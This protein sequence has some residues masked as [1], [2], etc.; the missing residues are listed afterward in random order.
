MGA[1]LLFAVLVLLAV[2]VGCHHRPGLPAIKDAGALRID[3]LDLYYMDGS[4]N[5]PAN[6]WPRAID[7]LYPISV[8]RQPD[9]IEILIKRKLGVE[10]RGYWICRD[11]DAKP[12][13]SVYKLSKTRDSGVYQFDLF[14]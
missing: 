5:I 6:K 14:K 8:L 3:C 9:H 12:E 11:P 7:S 4:D 13:S 10:A 2:Y 1:R